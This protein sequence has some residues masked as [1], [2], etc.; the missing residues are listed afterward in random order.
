MKKFWSN[1]RSEISKNIPMAQVYTKLDK[2]TLVV[3]T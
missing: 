2:E 3:D 1:D